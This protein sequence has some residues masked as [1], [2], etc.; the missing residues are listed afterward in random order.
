MDKGRDAGITGWVDFAGSLQFGAKVYAW[1]ED[2]GIS[3]TD[4]TGQG[5]GD[6]SDSLA[7]IENG[8]LVLTG[9]VRQDLFPFPATLKDASGTVTFT[10]NTGY[11]ARAA[12]KM[13]ATFRVKKV[14]TKFDEKTEGMWDLTIEADRLGALSPTGFASN[15]S[16]PTTTARTPGN[17]YLYAN[18]NKIVDPATVGP[19]VDQSRQ[20]FNVWGVPADTDAAELNAII[21]IIAGYSTPPQSR[22]KVYTASVE[23]LSSSV[24]RVILE[25]KQ[26]TSQR[27]IEVPA[28]SV[29]IDPND[30]TSFVASGIVYA[31]SAAFPT[32]SAPSGLK[33]V[34][35]ITT[36]LN[37]FLSVDKISYEKNDSKD[38]LELPATVTFLDNSSL[39]SH[40][41]IGRLNTTASTLTGF[42]LRE[43]ETVQITAAGTPHY[44]NTT[45]FGLRSTAQDILFPGNFTN[46]DN[47]SLNTTALATLL[48]NSSTT[49]FS[50]PSGLKILSSK[51][52]RL[53]GSL[54]AADQWQGTWE[55]ATRDSADNIN[56]P[57][58]VSTRSASDPFIDKDPHIIDASGN[59]PTQANSLWATFQSVAYAKGLRLSPLTDGKRLLVYEYRNPGVTVSGRTRSGARQIRARMSGGNPQLFVQDVYA[60]SATRALVVLSMV[61]NYSAE[62]RDF[63]LFRQL[64]G[65]TIPENSGSTINGVALP[66]IGQINNNTFLG[67]AAGNVQYAGPKYKVN[68]G[69]ASA[70]AFAIFIGY[71]FHENS[72]G[73][74]DGVPS[75]IF[76]RRLLLQLASIPSRQSWVNASALGFPGVA[77]PS[78]ASFSAFTA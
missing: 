4:N 63:V 34:D 22:E 3:S 18:R 61:L 44:F 46:Q 7:L 43:T 5:S 17:T 65:S 35:Q 60:Y 67:I 39:Q 21:G 78:A 72:L 25:W 77:Q 49:T 68:I 9:K 52:V 15:G 41:T 8:N 76:Q 38:K 62:I 30:I 66:D 54:G 58:T 11:G 47:N 20:M 42:S 37:E 40:A 31:L 57:Q 1:E 69:L 51:T 73:I 50:A 28:H 24:V 16:Q 36:Q 6:L 48:S 13:V 55:L 74:I 27:A 75:N 71:A 59:V 26:L 56:F 2:T 29:R 64:T 19:I 12:V 10:Y 53:T 14:T 23:R 32:P 45:K 70:G 33:L